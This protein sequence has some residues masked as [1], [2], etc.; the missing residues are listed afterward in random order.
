MELSTHPVS[1]ASLVIPAHPVL[2]ASLVIQHSQCQKH[3]CV[4]SVPGPPNTLGVRNVPGHLSTPNVRRVAGHP[5][6]PSA[7]SATL[8]IYRH[9]QCQDRSVPGHL[10]TA[11]IVPGYLSTAGG[12]SGRDMAA[13][14]RRPAAPILALCAITHR[15]A[16]AAGGGP[17]EGGRRAG[18]TAP[19]STARRRGSS[20]GGAGTDLASSALRPPGNTANAA[21]PHGYTAN[22]WW[23][24]SGRTIMVGIEAYR[25]AARMASAVTVPVPL[26][27]EHT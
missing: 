11:A 17:A 26:H 25:G 20:G 21:R 27:G 6:K 10:D 3:P 22:R 4:R 7:S 24:S 13:A 2:G 16:A 8:A 1:G 9:T 18:R 14:G 23:G 15:P 5:D 19:L 12:I